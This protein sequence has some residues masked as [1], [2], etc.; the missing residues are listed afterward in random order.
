MKYFLLPVLILALTAGNVAAQW[1][2]K[3]DDDPFGNDKKSISMTMSDGYGFGFSCQ[4]KDT[5]QLVYLTTEKA[6]DDLSGAKLLSPKLKIKV[7]SLDVV[8]LSA[9]I[10]EAGGKLRISSSEQAAVDV[11]KSIA[12]AKQRV[13]V[14][15]EFAGQRYHT[16]TFGVSG[17]KDALNKALRS[18]KL[19]GQ[20]KS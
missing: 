17:S 3:T 19:D 7:D 11:A 1:I 8:D 12:L 10:D 14:A 2:N 5:F 16:Q 20:P 15:I 4:G 18:C 6:G 13:A 9:D